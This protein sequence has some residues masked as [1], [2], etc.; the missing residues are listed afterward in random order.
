MIATRWPDA[1]KSNGGGCNAI[2]VRRGLITAHR[3]RLVSLVP[4]RR[5]VHAVRLGG[6]WLANVHSGASHR[7][8]RLSAA[9]SA[10]W[11]GPDP[12]VLGGDFNLHLFSLEGF[13]G[14]ADTAW[15]TYS[16]GAWRGRSPR[17]RS[18]TAAPC[19]ITRRWS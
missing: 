16:S 4:E 5:L 6:V 2:L 18:S 11:A 3:A 12:V 9:A 15:I 17:S 19:R 14:P 1:I 7:Q 13:S 8:A 10:A